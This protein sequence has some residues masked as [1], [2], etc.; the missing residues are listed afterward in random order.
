MIII[1]TNTIILYCE[2][3]LTFQDSL[4]PCHTDSESDRKIR[5][6]I[7]VI[8]FSIPFDHRDRQSPRDNGKRHTIAFLRR[9]IVVTDHYTT[10]HIVTAMV[11]HNVQIDTQHCE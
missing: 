4:H 6:I 1:H 3:W 9:H 10:I 5:S 8:V 2:I 11:E 7:P